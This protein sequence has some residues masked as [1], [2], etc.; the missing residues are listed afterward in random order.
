MF[1][2]VRFDSFKALADTTIRLEPLTVLVG[3]NGCGKSTALEGLRWMA[4]CTASEQAWWDQNAK[5]DPSRYAT[6]GAG[7][8]EVALSFPREAHRIEVALRRTMGE[9]ST[10]RIIEWGR[11]GQDGEE[12]ALR[13]QGDRF[14]QNAFDQA[15]AHI[16]PFHH[17]EVRLLQLSIPSLRQPSVTRERRPRME[18]DGAGLGAVLGHLAKAD[19]DAFDALEKDLKAVV[20]QVKS[21]VVESA[22][23]PGMTVYGDLAAVEIEHMGR[24]LAPDLSEGTLLTLA[25]LAELHSPGAPDVLLLDDIDRGLHPRAQADLLDCLRRLMKQ[26]P[27]LQIIATSHSPYL[28]DHLKPEE[29]VVMALDERSRAHARR[30]SDHPDAPRMQSL[31]RTGEFWASVGESWVL[32]TDAEQP[33]AA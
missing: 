19:R 24:I 14:S 16:D 22:E 31:L 5:L 13:R 3:S 26:R 11:D 27:A 1:S 18:A 20:P 8:F 9:A 17:Q 4:S 28:L 23:M 6:S 21:L 15:R 33:D 25:L 32:E 10:F 2:Q 29:V 12:R 7:S 30:L